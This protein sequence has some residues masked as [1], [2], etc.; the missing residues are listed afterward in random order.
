MKIDGTKIQDRENMPEDDYEATLTAVDLVEK[1]GKDPY[2]KEV[3]TV[4]DGEFAGRKLTSNQSLGDN[5]L[6]AFKERMIALGTDPDDFDGEFDPLEMA[7]D[8]IGNDCIIVVGLKT[9]EGRES[10]EIKRVKST[11]AVPA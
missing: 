9:Y 4:S 3:F 8:N 5:S 1:S 2:L 7:R 10:N 6:W 11:D